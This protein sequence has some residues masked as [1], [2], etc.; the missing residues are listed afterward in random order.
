MTEQEARN[1]FMDYLYDEMEEAQKQEF[2]QMITDN[3]E[4]QAELDELQQTRKLLKKIPFEKPSS[5]MPVTGIAKKNPAGLQAQKSKETGYAGNFVLYYLL[6][7]AAVFLATILTFSFVNL[8]IGTGEQGFYM[9]FGDVPVQNEQGISEEDL[10]GLLDQIRTEN[11]L[12][13]ASMIEQT[14][15]QQT[16]Q[17]EEVLSALT[18][19]YDQ[20]RRQ[21]LLLIAEGLS[22]LEEDTY[23]RFLQ[24]DETLGEIIYALSNTN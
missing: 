23:Y 20:R 14:Q 2:E 10:I 22:Q 9:Q 21:D 3:A 13:A 8:Q 1:L 19:Y 16:E 24:T 7:I 5:E 15:T 6:P 18:T 11:A 4:L 17:L 12:L